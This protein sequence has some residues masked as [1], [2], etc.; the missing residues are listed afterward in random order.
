MTAI[1]SK[2]KQYVSAVYFAGVN[3]DPYES[4]PIPK[5]SLPP[6]DL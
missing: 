1:L 4:P 6:G 5:H 3:V 2:G